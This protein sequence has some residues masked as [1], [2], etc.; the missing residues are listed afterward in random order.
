MGACELKRQAK[1]E[2]WKMQ[3]IDCRSSGMSVRGM[4][5]GTQYIDK[6]L[7]PLGKGNPFVGSRGTCARSFGTTATS[8]FCR[9]PIAA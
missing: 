9:T 2:H 6:D 3:I 4:V 7:L 5:R 1:L 8:N